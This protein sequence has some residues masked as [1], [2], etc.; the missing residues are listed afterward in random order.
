MQCSPITK[1]NL[2]VQVPNT[3]YLNAVTVVHRHEATAT[4]AYLKHKKLVVLIV[5][6]Y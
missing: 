5:V 6:K 3:T 2:L 4:Q 1:H